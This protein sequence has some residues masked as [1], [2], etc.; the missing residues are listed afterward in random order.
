MA[1]ANRN[2]LTPVFA[3]FSDRDERLCVASKTTQVGKVIS[4]LQIGR[5]LRPS[6]E[7]VS[8][9]PLSKGTRRVSCKMG[10]GRTSDKD[11]R[12]IIVHGM[13]N[14]GFL[15]TR[16][17]GGF[18]ISEVPFSPEGNSQGR[19]DPGNLCDVP[20]AEFLRRAKHARRE[21]SRRRDR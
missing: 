5:E 3:V 1:S 11:Q 20:T 10:F 6:A 12:T 9:L 13:I 21:G 4:V 2:S 7:P 14:Y 8:L 18:P 17:I 16:D 19:K 15:V